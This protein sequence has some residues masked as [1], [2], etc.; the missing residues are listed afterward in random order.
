[1]ADQAHVGGDDGASAVTLRRKGTASKRASVPS[2]TAPSPPCGACKFLRR[3]CLNGC[4]FAPYFGSDQGAAR[5]AAV[6]KVFGAS[7][8][9]KL[10]LH[11]PTDRRHEAV[12]TIS[13]EAQARLADP[14]YGCVST[15]LALQQQVA[16]LQGELAMVQ[17][18]VINS[19]FAY[20]SVLQNTQQQQQQLNMMNVTMQQ[21][22]Y[23]NNN[24]STSCTNLMN[25]RC[26]NPFDLTTETAPSSHS[27]DP[28]RLSQDEEDDEEESRIPQVFNNDIALNR[29]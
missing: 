19:R 4:I 18:Q 2:A 7:N 13:Y 9:S 10:L 27:F 1:M 5:F 23:S 14:V 28:I 11:I 15:I 8:V 21:P 29:Q 16:S 25:M 26:F 12:V 22:A 20:A 6:H 24:S 17:D 3:K